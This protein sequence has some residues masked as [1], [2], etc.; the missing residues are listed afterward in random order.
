MHPAVI[1]NELEAVLHDW[2]SVLTGRIIFGEIY[3]SL[4]ILSVRLCSRNVSN[5]DDERC[6]WTIYQPL[7]KATKLTPDPTKRF[8]N[9]EPENPSINI[10]EL[11]KIRRFADFGACK[12]EKFGLKIPQQ[13]S[14]FFF[15]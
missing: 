1:E 13:S 8:V 5:P 2:P 4:F 15:D 3:Y 11:H 9:L 12:C 6:E 14:K 7:K 10:L